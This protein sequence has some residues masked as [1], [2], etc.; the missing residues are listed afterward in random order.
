MRDGV[1]K[2]AGP[3]VSVIVP[4]YNAAEYLERA[5]GSAL[6]QTMPDHE[7]IVVDDASTD[8]TLEVAH[9]VA[10]RDPRVRVLHNRRN[11]GPSA[12]R[13]LAMHA[14]TRG[15][16]IALLDA[17][18][19]WLPER[20][21][22]MLA[23]ADDADVVSDDIRI[24]TSSKKV[25]VSPR[26]LTILIRQGFTITT[27]SQL[28]ILE[29][30]TSGN[31]GLLK[32]I[33][34]RSFLKRYGLEFKFDFGI[35][36]DFHL[37]FEMLASGARWLQLP[38][39]YYVYHL[40]TNNMSRDLLML[41]RDVIKSTEALLNHPAAA[42]DPVLAAALERRIQEWKSHEAFA[43]A[44]RLLRQRRYADLARLLLHQPSYLSLSVRKVVRAIYSRILWWFRKHKRKRARQW[45][46]GR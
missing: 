43:I 33:I 45:G 37:Y 20:L 16:W 35:V 38:D 3:R 36:H 30:A 8:N 24:V 32:P 46:H 42:A 9:R 19:E 11:R 1:E 39:S 7:V 12:T 6:D 2:V 31:L 13:N 34:R 29:F 4:A 22:K 25:F 15:E 26:W 18:D 23:V 14:T 44:W 17:D 40:H 21:E 10:A 5:L 28:K 27:P 41:A